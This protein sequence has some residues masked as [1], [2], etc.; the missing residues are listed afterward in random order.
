MRPLR[1]SVLIM[2]TILFMAGCN[3]PQVNPPLPLP[4]LPWAWTMTPFLPQASTFTPDQSPVSIA[5]LSA[6]D[7]MATTAVRVPSAGTLVINGT[8]KGIANKTASLGSTL[9]PSTSPDSTRTSS[10]TPSA[11]VSPQPCSAPDSWILYTVQPGDTP[12]ALA[13]HVGINVTEL[14][15]ANCLSSTASIFAGEPLY[16]PLAGQGPTVTKD[17]TPSSPGGTESPT[18][19]SLTF[20]SGGG[21]GSETGIPP[22]EE[23]TYQSSPLSV[24]PGEPVEVRMMNFR[25]RQKLSVLVYRVK[26]NTIIGSIV[27]GTIAVMD[28]SGNGSAMINT[29]RLAP[30]YYRVVVEG[31]FGL[32]ADKNT[33]Q[34]FPPPPTL[35]ATTPPPVATVTVAATTQP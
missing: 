25:P 24:K 10:P 28:D 5:V 30:G 20:H 7:A 6:Q 26:A 31:L 8:P 1:I 2:L 12:E 16:L 19:D 27:W 21:G 4:T 17:V 15:E 13:D 18:P 22:G 29:D 34:V 35:S 11:T 32:N 3:L 33:F 14:R 9:I 23:K